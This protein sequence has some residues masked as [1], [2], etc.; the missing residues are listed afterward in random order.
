MPLG[1]LYYKGYWLMWFQVNKYISV[2][3]S[4]HIAKHMRALEPIVARARFI[5]EEFIQNVTPLNMY[6]KKTPEEAK[7]EQ[8]RFSV[9]MQWPT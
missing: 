4:V 1:I 3:K 8:V 7:M 9:N 2:S 6:Q 5:I